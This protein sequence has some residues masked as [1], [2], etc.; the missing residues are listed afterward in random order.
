MY[1]RVM[2]RS[3]LTPEDLSMEAII[4]EIPHH[5]LGEVDKF[6]PILLKYGVFIIMAAVAVEGF[7]IP[8]PGQTLLITAAILSVRGNTSIYTVMLAAWFAAVG[9]SAIGYAIGRVGGRKLLQWLPVSAKRLERVEA[10]CLHYGGLFI[11]VSRFFDGLRQFGSI[12]VGS[13]NMPAL[14]FVVMTALGA[15][16][17]VG[18]WG[19]GIYYLDQRIHAIAADFSQMSSYTWVAMGVLIVAVVVYLIGG[20][21]KTG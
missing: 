21:G 4:A 13:L 8:A 2:G 1:I 9:G 18:V 11:V 12:L 17:W 20:R 6:E 19:M 16:L 5:L 7:G 14:Q 10:L 3:Q 15:A